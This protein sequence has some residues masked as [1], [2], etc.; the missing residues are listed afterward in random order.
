MTEIRLDT[1]RLTGGW[2]HPMSRSLAA[3]ARIWLA[4]RARAKMRKT[5]DGLD[6]TTL[7]DIGLERNATGYGPAP[8][9][10]DIHRRRIQALGTS[11]GLFR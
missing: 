1:P 2:F 7:R 6:E 3:L 5:L 9:V 11:F 4:W 8:G 10:S